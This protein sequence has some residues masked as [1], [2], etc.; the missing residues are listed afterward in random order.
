MSGLYLAVGR[1][2]PVVTVGTR[3]LLAVCH[4]EHICMN[5]YVYMYVYI[6][7]CV[8]VCVCVCVSMWRAR[9]GVGL[10]CTG[11]RGLNV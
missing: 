8:C 4:Y 7:V 9:L 6:Y 5:I 11:G 2:D 3:V 1:D 10:V